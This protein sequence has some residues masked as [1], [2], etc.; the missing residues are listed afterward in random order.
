MND[1]DFEARSAQP[2]HRDVRHPRGAGDRPVRR[3]VRRSRNRRPAPRPLDRA[4]D[5]NPPPPTRSD[6]PRPR[7]RGGR[8][9][10]GEAPP[11]AERG[12]WR[13]HLWFRRGSA[14]HNT[15]V[16]VAWIG[17]AGA[18]CGP[19]VTVVVPA[20]WT[21]TGG[22]R[23]TPQHRMATIINAPGGVTYAYKQPS[24]FSEH[25]EKRPSYREGDAIQVVC[26]IRDGYSVS[27][28]GDGRPIHPVSVWNK[29]PNGSWI[30]DIFT[31]L[32]Q[33]KGPNPPA[34]I[35]LCPEATSV[36]TP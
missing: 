15:A 9:A 27:M 10:D 17:F 16:A 11:D 2:D 20:L 24:L 36:P 31:N 21:L 12:S 1:E 34:G 4:R 30:P 18:V 3:P 6:D 26:Q 29:L 5:A 35:E 23:P 7:R 14:V 28:P 32:P 13:R 19:L 25:A 33:K 22:S 8:D